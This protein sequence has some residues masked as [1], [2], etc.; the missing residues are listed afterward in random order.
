MIYRQFVN[1]N[2]QLRVFRSNII[3]VLDIYFIDFLRES[4]KSKV[5]LGF[6]QI[7]YLDLMKFCSL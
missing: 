6:P 1:A 3:F 5:F 4:K 7:Y 2:V